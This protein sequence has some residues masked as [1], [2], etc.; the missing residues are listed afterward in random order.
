MKDSIGFRIFV[1]FKR[2]P[3]ETLALFA[4]IPAS[5]LSDVMNRMYAMR[6]DIVPFN[7]K[8]LLGPAFTVKVPMGDNL[9]FHKALDLFKPGD[10]L[11]VD[12]EGALDRSLAGEILVAYAAA[13]GAA[14]LVF[15]GAVRDGAGMRG[16]DIPVYA[17]GVSPQGPYKRGPGE[18]NVPVACGG[19]VVFPGDIVIG[20][21]DGVTVVPQE[22]A[23][24]I[25]LAAR[26]KLERE[27][28]LLAQARQRA[29]D[30]KEHCAVYNR[31]VGP[32]V[33]II[34]FYGMQ[35]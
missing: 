22:H 20:D 34:P 29:I 13:R 24:D 8:P 2:P 12:G 23:A 1:D 18:I 28:A 6:H 11:V 4:G 9:L 25:A 19:Q 32:D 26:K 16:A 31:L 17:K 7:D 15:D 5:T 14:G 30:E 10:V 35:E 33:Q 3:K 21:A 27:D